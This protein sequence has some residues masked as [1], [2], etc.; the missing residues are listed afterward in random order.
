MALDKQKQPVEDEDERR[1]QD[2]YQLAALI[3]DI[4]IESNRG[5]PTTAEPKSQAS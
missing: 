5:K 3:Y 4:Y 2:A 1:K